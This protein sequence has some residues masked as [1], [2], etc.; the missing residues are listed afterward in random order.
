LPGYEIPDGEIEHPRAWVFVFDIDRD[1]T[2]SPAPLKTLYR[3]AISSEALSTY[4]FRESPRKAIEQGAIDNFRRVLIN[5]RV[6]KGWEGK[7]LPEDTPPPSEKSSPASK[8]SEEPQPP[9]R[10]ASSR[11]L[12]ARAASPKPIDRALCG[13]DAGG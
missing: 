6:I 3:I 4:A 7:P 2:E 11:W 10:G 13:R 5:E 12:P 9:R 8:R 1:S